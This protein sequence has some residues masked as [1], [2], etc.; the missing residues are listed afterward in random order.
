MEYV[1]GADKGS[2]L[3]KWMPRMKL[4]SEEVDGRSCET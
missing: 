1:S 2:L 3:T 4:L